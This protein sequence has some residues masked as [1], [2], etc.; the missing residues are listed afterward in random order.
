MQDREDRLERKSLYPSHKETKTVEG[1]GREAI[2]YIIA[3]LL[4]DNLMI[5]SLFNVFC[6]SNL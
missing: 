6:F 1:F 3:Q 2:G 4:I 5:Q